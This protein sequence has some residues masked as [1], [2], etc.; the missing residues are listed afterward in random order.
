MGFTTDATYAEEEA[1]APPPAEPAPAPAAPPAAEGFATDATY[2]AEAPAPAPTTAQAVSPP[3]EAQ[4]TPTPVQDAANALGT[5]VQERVASPIA[6]VVPAPVKEAVGPVLSGA[7]GLLGEAASTPPK[8]ADA[9]LG[10]QGL[11]G[12]VESGLEPFVQMG[13][14]GA[15]R[16]GERAAAGE[17]L[18]PGPG[19]IL[20]DPS[21]ALDVLPGALVSGG[22]GAFMQGEQG[23]DE[24]RQA[25]PEEARA[26][27]E[28][29]GGEAV[30][31]R[32]K[33][34]SGLVETSPRGVDS[35]VDDEEYEGN[36]A[37]R[38]GQLIGETVEWAGSVK[39]SAQAGT[40]TPFLRNMAIDTALDPS[41]GVQ[42]AAA[43]L[44]G[45]A[46][47]GAGAAGRAGMPALA[48]GL[49]TV[50]R[51]SR[52]AEQAA[53]VVLD[54]VLSTVGAAGRAAAGPVARRVPLLQKSPASQLAMEQARIADVAAEYVPTRTVNT[55]AA[56][57]AA[58][59]TPGAGFLPPSPHGATRDPLAR[60][61]PSVAAPPPPAAPVSEL[62]R[63]IAGVRYRPRAGVAA[64]PPRPD[65]AP[66]PWQRVGSPAPLRA[67]PRA[68][69]RP[70]VSPAT[71]RVLTPRP[72]APAPRDGLSVRGGR[73][74]DSRGRE[75]APGNRIVDTAAARRAYDEM[76]VAEPGAFWD[77]FDSAGPSA[78]VARGAD[79]HYARWRAAMKQGLWLLE[80]QPLGRRID[81]R[82]AEAGRRYHD[83]FAQ[84]IARAADPDQE[85][86]NLLATYHLDQASGRFEGPTF[87]DDY[88]RRRGE[89]IAQILDTTGYAPSPAMLARLAAKPLDQLAAENFPGRPAPPAFV[90]KTMRDGARPALVRP[91]GRV[92]SLPAGHTAPTATTPSGAPA[93]APAEI[94]V[95]RSLGPL[96]AEQRNRIAALGGLDAPTSVGTTAALEETLPFKGPLGGGPVREMTLRD[97]LD[98]TD[99]ELERWL[100][101]A[102]DPDLRARPAVE[103][104]FQRLTKKFSPPQ[105]AVDPAALDE[106][107]RARL[108]GAYAADAYGAAKAIPKAKRAGLLG[109]VIDA[110]TKYLGFRRRAQLYNPLN[111]ARFAMQQHLGNAIVTGIAG[112]PKAALR[113]FTNLGVYR[114]THRYLQDPGAT[115]LFS[116]D[117]QAQMGSGFRRNITQSDRASL[118]EA[119]GP[120]GRLDEP[121]GLSRIVAPNWLVNVGKISDT[122]TRVE[123]FADGV[124]SGYRALNRDLVPAVLEISR[125]YGLPYT[126]AGVR[127]VIDR[128]FA[129]HRTVVDRA[130]GTPHTDMLGRVARYEPVYSAKEL[131]DWLAAELP[132]LA[133]PTSATHGDPLGLLTRRVRGDTQNAI[134]AIHEAAERGVNKAAFDWLPTTL[135]E[136]AQ[137]FF[138]YHFWTTRAGGLYVTQA[139]K[140]PAAMAAYGRMMEDFE[141]QAELL[142][143]PD[144]MRGFFRFMNTPAGFSIWYAPTDLLQT[145][146]TFA[147]WQREGGGDPF[148]DLTLA[149]RLY[150]NSPVLFNPLFASILQVAG[151]FGPDSRPPDLLGLGRAGT[152]AAQLLNLA[153]MEGAPGMEVANALGIGVDA[154]G[155]KVLLPPR[156]LEE[157]TARLLRPFAV[158]ISEQTGLRPISVPNS[159]AT[160][161]V[162]VALRV[163]QNLRLDPANAGLDQA[164]INDMARV[165]LADH[166][167]AEYQQAARE[168]AGMPYMTPDTPLPG[169]AEGLLR[170]VSPI[171]I[172]PFVE[173]RLLDSTMKG[174]PPSGDVPPRNLDGDDNAFNEAKY[175]AQ[176]TPEG[177]ALDAA[178]DGYYEAGGAD[179]VMEPILDGWQAIRYGDAAEA[180]I[181]GGVEYTPQD[182]AAI[183]AAEGDDSPT[184]KALAKQWVGEQG[185]SLDALFGP[186]GTE[187]GGYAGQKRAAQET[188]LDE[189]PEVAAYLDW[190]G[191]RYTDYK[192]V[193]D[194]NGYPVA[195]EKAYVE[196]MMAEN[197]AF[198]DY[199]YRNA[200]D[201]D[202]GAINYSR[203]LGTDAYLAA[204]GTRPTVYEPLSGPDPA[205]TALPTPRRP[206]VHATVPLK[207]RSAPDAGG[208]NV[209]GAVDP[210]LPMTL[211][212]TEGAWSKVIVGGVEGYVAS[213]YLQNAAPG[214]LEAVGAALGSAVGGLVGAVQG[215]LGG[216]PGPGMAPAPPVASKTAAAPGSF[217][218]D[219]TTYAGSPNR[220]HRS[221]PPGGLVFHY[222]VGDLDSFMADFMGQT[223]RQASSNYVVDRDGTIYELI[224]P[225]QAAWTHGDTSNPRMDLPWLAE[226]IA[227][228]YNMNDRAIGIEIV[229]AGNAA[230]PGSDDPADYEPYTAEQ[231]AALEWLTAYLAQRYGIPPSRDRLLAHSDINTSDKYDPG[232]AFP[233]ERI[234]AAAGT[235]PA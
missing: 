52:A 94:A 11:G 100:D 182:L 191:V 81:A 91:N 216:S 140:N 180:M 226:Q 145:V 181:V 120:T 89:A 104:D 90:G 219:A 215:A 189:H 127:D 220:S 23:L 156:P 32:W 84:R 172:T 53:E 206:Q 164:A 111:I 185:S 177:R 147:D 79:G 154:Q 217:A 33:A 27:Y 19:A 144:W 109:S 41:V 163:E 142:G 78:D 225:D 166:G 161:S 116:D 137:Q 165:I 49:G 173:Q 223:G 99:R 17:N 69:P 174:M 74:R 188:Y 18:V 193:T 122:N 190:K 65:I 106:A 70:A 171:Q 119:M 221:A 16:A 114:R 25:N 233:W 38:A 132:K 184:L 234:L 57:S 150:D 103:A 128:F 155:N 28:A 51:G 39:D 158:A 77:R 203:A 151:A 175:G 183:A 85:V 2:A 76:M 126:E 228:G 195:P 67:A 208:D 212:E 170:Q 21:K 48:K 143:A 118:G 205:G 45:G 125:K 40:L 210:S 194:E 179:P 199:V 204:R 10:G 121:G 66:D 162:E 29:G 129:A 73:W 124:F 72:A 213:G 26:A 232:P 93:A 47:L 141:A 168:V 230:N 95:T 58:S 36:A 115:T 59:V 110:N 80:D 97:F 187:G 192:G 202:T 87:G 61:Q 64:R 231:V 22:V 8:M 198:A 63:T 169:V 7:S 107:G 197:P 201:L 54:P 134:R 130:A 75:V 46:S 12:V 35:P 56:A 200:Y 62:N 167:S 112:R 60:G 227:A 229:N 101:L 34:D 211:L 176:K 139:L 214:P 82:R 98:E 108:V 37:E 83:L 31:E 43:A 159:G 117:L 135:D 131:V 50:A 20:A 133:P 218:I 207:V 209:I 6:S 30:V 160:Q 86:Y 153:N 148:A 3:A 224:D 68:A 123:L 152:M 88:W 178:L 24:W 186:Y 157:L 196:A 15:E 14:W 71:G 1:V 146:L 44:T 136:K 138:L 13:R 9:L 55:P 102:N 5:L 222:T 4:A 105:T 149:G 113:T 92:V 96:R 235:A 42:L